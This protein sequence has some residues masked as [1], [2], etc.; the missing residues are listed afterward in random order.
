[1][2]SFLN[3]LTLALSQLRRNLSRSVLTSLGVL[4]GVAAVITMVGLGQGATASIEGDL[5]SMGSNLLIV[6]SGTGGG[7]HLHTSA[8]PFQIA[9]VHAIRASVPYLAA[10]APQVNAAATAVIGDTEW[11]TSITGSNNDYLI[12]SNWKLASGRSFSEGGV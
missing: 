12:L 2:S 1:M 8:P 7:P 9:D 4:I 3:A 11:S 10:V 6:Q 5:A